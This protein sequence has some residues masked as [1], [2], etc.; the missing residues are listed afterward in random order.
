[1][2]R[3]AFV[4]VLLVLSLAAGCT[5]G[6]KQ[7]PISQ[8]PDFT[9][10]DLSGRSVRLSDLRGKVVLVEFWATWCPPC[11]A[12]VPVIEHLHKT[13]AEKGLVVLGISI[14]EQW[15]SV[16]TFAREKG[17]SYAV[18]RGN[19]EVSE[20]YM[21]RL[22]PTMFLVGKDGMIAKQYVGGEEEDTLATDVRSLL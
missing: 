14:D 1:M 7:G 17:I 12:S 4:L 21:V 8:A 13:F 20:Q 6:E 18:L 3:N 9:L 2:F 16:R 19:E 22:V 15:D 11:R 5:R 10:Q